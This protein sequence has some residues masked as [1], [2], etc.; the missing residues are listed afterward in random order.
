M[1]LSLS[2]DL[3]FLE[4]TVVVTFL[5]HAF[6]SLVCLS[7]RIQFIGNLEFGILGNR[8]GAAGSD[9][10]LFSANVDQFASGTF[11]SIFCVSICLI[12]CLF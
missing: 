4:Q 1:K 8:F 3:S 12:V 11:A 2:D 5:D 9:E 10:A 7:K 6:N